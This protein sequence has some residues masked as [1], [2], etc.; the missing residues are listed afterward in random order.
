MKFPHRE[1]R[2]PRQKETMPKL[3]FQYPNLKWKKTPFSWQKL[4]T[5]RQGTS[6]KKRQRTIYVPETSTVKRRRG[7]KTVQPESTQE[8]VQTKQPSH[9]T[10]TEQQG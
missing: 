2:Q 7:K 3:K 4:R 1:L 5:Y 8:T 6:K 10:P 9:E